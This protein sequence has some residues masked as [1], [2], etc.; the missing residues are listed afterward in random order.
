M[1][2]NIGGK[3]QTVN[4]VFYIIIKETN[5]EPVYVIPDER[6]VG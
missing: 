2:K 5:L 6:R 1:S 4:N 3:Q